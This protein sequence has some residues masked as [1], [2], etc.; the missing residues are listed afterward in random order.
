MIATCH[1]CKGSGVLSDQPM[2]NR[3]Y[4][5]PCLVCDGTGQRHTADEHTTER[6]DD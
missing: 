2:L 3:S 4:S 6:K 5:G 1:F